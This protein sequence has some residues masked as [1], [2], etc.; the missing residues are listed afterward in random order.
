MKIVFSIL[1]T[2]SVIFMNICV[3]GNVLFWVYLIESIREPC[4]I[5]GFVP[6]LLKH[7]KSED[8]MMATQ[9]C[10]ALGNIC[11]ENGMST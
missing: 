1:N 2:F 6:V 11:F 3:L 9:A 5:Q 8:I 10:R 4:V 7:L